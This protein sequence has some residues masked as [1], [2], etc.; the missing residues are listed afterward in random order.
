MFPVRVRDRNKKKMTTIEVIPNEKKKNIP[1]Y[2]YV[3]YN[4]LWIY[5][6]CI[7]LNISF[8]V[9]FLFNDFMAV[10]R[11]NWL[12]N[13]EFFINQWILNRSNT[14]SQLYAHVY[15]YWNIIVI[16]ISPRLDSISKLNTKERKKKVVIAKEAHK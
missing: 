2:I 11:A 3:E 13:V 15:M 1:I 14:Q 7:S 16:I 8:L 6:R 5:K 4:D 9:V 10:K 12:T